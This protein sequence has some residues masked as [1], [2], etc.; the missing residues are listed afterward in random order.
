[1]TIKRVSRVLDGKLDTAN[2]PS[3]RYKPKVTE[4]FMPEPSLVRGASDLS[5]D[6]SA[7]AKLRSKKGTHR[8]MQDIQDSSLPD[9]LKKLLITQRESKQ[10]II[11]KISELQ[12]VKNNL[13]LPADLRKQRTLMIQTEIMAL[14]TS[15]VEALNRLDHLMTQMGVSDEQADVVALLLMS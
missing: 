1:M 8:S 6:L 10:N 9:I 12:K 13:Q 5:V 3:S 14:E 4:V 7:A 2:T 11:R 15:Y